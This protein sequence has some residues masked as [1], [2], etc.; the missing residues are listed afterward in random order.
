MVIVFELRA[1]VQYRVWENNICKGGVL[2]ERYIYLDWNVV[3]YAISPRKSHEYFDTEIVEIVNKINKKGHA[4]IFLDRY[5]Y[6]PS[7]I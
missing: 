6:T 1:I 5:A 7:I 4:D 3:K 2:M